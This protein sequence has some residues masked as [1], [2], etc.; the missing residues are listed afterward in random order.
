ME[1]TRLSTRTQ[2]EFTQ[3]QL[4][5][6]QAALRTAELNLEYATIR[7]PIGGRIGDSWCRWA[8]WSLLPRPCR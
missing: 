2:I 7:A 4:E 8:A 5:T 1:Q 6:N 3:A